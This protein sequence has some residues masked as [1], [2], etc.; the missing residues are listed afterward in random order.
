MN[1]LSNLFGKKTEE[2]SQ[3][4]Y[5]M[6]I[7]INWTWDQFRII[8][9]RFFLKESRSEFCTWFVRG[10]AAGAIVVLIIVFF[11]I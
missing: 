5:E 10:F 11:V 6:F 4:P 7:A 9:R 3:H 2:A 1:R 8:R